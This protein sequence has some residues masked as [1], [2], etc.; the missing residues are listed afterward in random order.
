MSAQYGASETSPLLR[1]HGDGVNGHLVD[2][3]NQHQNGSQQTDGADD[4]ALAEEP[5]TKKLILTLSAIWIGVFFAALGT[6]EDWQEDMLLISNIKTPPLLLPSQLQY[7]PASTPCLSCH[8][9]PP[10]I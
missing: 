10:V 7:P 8:G 9:L 6:S 5:E 4:T 3:E 2:P 1:E